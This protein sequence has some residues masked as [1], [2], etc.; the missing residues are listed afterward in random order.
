MEA[1]FEL[2]KGLIKD[3]DGAPHEEVF[4]V[5]FSLV[6]ILLFVVHRHVFSLTVYQYML[7]FL[8]NS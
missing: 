6:L 3:L 7:Y 2:I 1:L 8:L 4:G 5:H